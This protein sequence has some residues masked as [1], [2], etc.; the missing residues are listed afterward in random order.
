MTKQEFK[1]GIVFSLVGL[2]VAIYGFTMLGIGTIGQ[3]GPGLFPFLSGLG[4]V[5][6][7]GIWVGGNWRQFRSAE[8]LWHKG[9]IARPLIAVIVIL[10]Y[11]TLMESL[12][13]ILTTLLFVI[14]W[15]VL[16]EREKWKKLIVIAIVSTTI[17]FLLFSYLLKLSLPDGVFGI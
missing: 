15:Q 4:I 17:M 11:A 5:V 8:P 13:Y 1:A 7:C 16:I 14:A 6:L 12:G 9:Q 2:S 10:A 3:P